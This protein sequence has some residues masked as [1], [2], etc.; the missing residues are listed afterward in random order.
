MLGNAKKRREKTGRGGFVQ[1]ASADVPDVRGYPYDCN[2]TRD[3]GNAEPILSN[4]ALSD[5]EPS[6]RRRQGIKM[7]RT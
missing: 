6:D 2:N 5:S 3:T 7:L 4:V 1:D